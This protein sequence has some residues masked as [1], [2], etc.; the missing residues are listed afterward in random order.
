VCLGQDSRADWR[1]API[2]ALKASDCALSSTGHALLWGAL[3]AFQNWLGSFADSS[4]SSALRFRVPVSLTL[5]VTNRNF[6]SATTFSAAVL[7]EFLYTASFRPRASLQL[8]SNHGWCLRECTPSRLQACGIVFCAADFMRASSLS[9]K[10]SLAL[11]EWVEWN[12]AAAQ[13][14]D[15]LD[16]LQPSEHHI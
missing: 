7:C 16:M 9:H 1:S 5:S 8:L 6:F 14:Q 10:T 2:K 13:L 3:K 12:V 15:T 4:H 11:A